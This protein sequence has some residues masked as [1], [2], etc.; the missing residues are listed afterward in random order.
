MLQRSWPRRTLK[1]KKANVIFLV[2]FEQKWSFASE[3]MYV[4]AS[5]FCL[6][7]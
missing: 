5:V 3:I 2:F 1:G 7:N 4:T 6:K